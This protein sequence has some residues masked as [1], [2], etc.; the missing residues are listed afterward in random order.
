MTQKILFLLMMI[1]SIASEAQ[2]KDSQ[3]KANAIYSQ[4]KDV[5]W[6]IEFLDKN[7]ILFS[8]KKGALKVL[9]LTTQKLKTIKN[10]PPSVEWGQGGFLDIHLHPKFSENK[11]LF[12][13]YTKQVADSYT[14]AIAS[15]K[16]EGDSLINFKEI[17]AANNPNRNGQHFGS[18]LVHDE[19]DFLYFS[20]GD[21]GER[22]LAQQ[23]DA[24]QG[25]IHRINF[26]GSVPK[27]NPF[28]KDKKSRATIWS[29]GHRNPQ[30]MVYD[31]KSKTLWVQEH[32]PRGGDEINRIEKGANYGWPEIT[33][34]REYYGPKIGTTAKEGMKQPVYHF[35]PSIA[36]SGLDLFNG[37][38]YSGALKLT[39]LN[40]LKMSSD[41]KAIKEIRHL[42][43]LK[44][45][46][47]DVKVGPDQKIYLSTDSGKIMR[48][49]TISK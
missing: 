18:R 1:T 44:E 3:L 40:Q 39:H 26:D 4:S 24:D 42:E 29:Y 46:I 30:G 5:I 35:T 13:S 36:P 21:R 38:L 7:Q 2:L 15:A 25:K 28:T 10:P 6:S 11:I 49:E 33:Y 34:G 48:V 14:T 37:D 23:L 31:F 43:D 17:F 8:E 32:G 16:L 12:F 22:N 9:D 45:R 19:N 47:R 20:V 41:G 27:D